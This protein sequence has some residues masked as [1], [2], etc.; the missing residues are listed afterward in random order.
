M[1]EAEIP[2]RVSRA[3][4]VSEAGDI[5]EVIYD[6][7]KEGTGEMKVGFHVIVHLHMMIGFGVLWRRLLTATMAIVHCKF[8]KQRHV[9]RYL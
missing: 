6:R 3:D 4:I 1:D 2:H 8:Y 5:E 9:Q 7:H